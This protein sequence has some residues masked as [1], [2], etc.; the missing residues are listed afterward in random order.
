MVYLECEFYLISNRSNIFNISWMADGLQY[1]KLLLLELER[2]FF[3]YILLYIQTLQWQG[4][5]MNDLMVV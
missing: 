2:I 3:K 5:K 1:A 4:K